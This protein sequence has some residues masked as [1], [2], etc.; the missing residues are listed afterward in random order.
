MISNRSKLTP[1]HYTWDGGGRG[2]ITFLEQFCVF[3]ETEVTRLLYG[4]PRFFFQELIILFGLYYWTM[5]S[6]LGDTL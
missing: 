2:Q 1:I 3:E 4:F 6:H 5:V